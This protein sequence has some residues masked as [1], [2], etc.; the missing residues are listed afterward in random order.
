MVNFG[1]N[2]KA[3]SQKLINFGLQGG[4]AH[5]AFTWGVLDRFLEEDSLT[6]SGVSGT[7]AG[8]MNAA[9]MASGYAVSGKSGARDAL[10]KYWQKIAEAARF[11][12]FQRSFFDRLLGQWTLD[13]ST[14]YALADLMGRVMSPYD[15]PTST[16][17]PMQEILDDIINFNAIA[18]GPIKLFITATNVATGRGRVF[19]SSEITSDVLLASACLPTV[20]RAIEIEGD[21]YWDGGYSG[22][23]TLLPLI[24]HCDAGDTII[25]QIN[26]YERRE[27]PTKARDIISRVNEISFNAVLIKELK[28]LALLQQVSQ[29]GSE[30]EFWKNQR[31]HLLKSDLMLDLGVSSK[32][33]A[34]WDFLIMLRDE[35]RSVA[36]DFLRNHSSDI[37][38]IS[39][40]DIEKHLKEN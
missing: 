9:V 25:V 19:S 32:M 29:K 18:S 38:E 21:Y 28:Y 30:Q 12:P 16:F 20:F 34:E 37:G 1:N 5:G 40:Y 24:E 22:N 4:G 39:T 8:A 17:N 27:L 3:K 11:S 23:P 13:F 15:I 31:I 2:M 26:P 6:I 36:E 35:G 33:N 7:S 10:D 14:T